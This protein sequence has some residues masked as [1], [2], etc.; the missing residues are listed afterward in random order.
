MNGN[1]TILA[2]NKILNRLIEFAK[3]VLQTK[4]VD[5]LTIDNG[6]VLINGV[7]SELKWDELINKAYLNRV[8]L[9]AQ[10]YYSTPEIHFDRNINQGSPFAYHVYGTAITTAVLDVI[11]GTY[12]IESVKIVHDFGK[13]LNKNIDVGQVEGALVQGIGWMTMEEIKY[14]DDG[15]LLAN[16]L[17]TYKIPDMYSTPENIEVEF[18]DNSENKFAPFNSKAIGEPPLMYG[19]G[20]YF[21]ILDAMKSAKPDKIFELSS[22]LTPEKVLMGLYS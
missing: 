1:A 9:S 11:R 17:S 12:K 3:K 7:K 6:I 22:P 21:A 16:A 14:S 20:A 13:S 10:A 5:L 19:I 2:C 15:R 4:E 18:L 8:S